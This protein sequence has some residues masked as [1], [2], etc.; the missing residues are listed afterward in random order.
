MMDSITEGLRSGAADYIGI[1]DTPNPVWIEAADELDRLRREL[2]EAQRDAGRY[3]W[4]RER[5]YKDGGSIYC[6]G[7]D[8]SYDEFAVGYLPDGLDAAIDAAMAEP[9]S[10][11]PD[12]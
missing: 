12:R 10:S 3:R 1:G 4:L 5:A 11:Q 9:E 6:A 2:A 8:G 7:P